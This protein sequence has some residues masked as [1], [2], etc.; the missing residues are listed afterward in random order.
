[1]N[2]KSPIEPIPDK[3]AELITFFENRGYENVKLVNHR[4][5]NDILYATKDGK[6]CF[7]KKFRHSTGADE[8]VAQKTNN[9][10]ACYKHLPKDL[11]I[12]VVEIAVNGGYV[13]LENVDFDETIEDKQYIQEIADFELCRLPNIEASFLSEIS[14]GNY[15]RLF[16]KLKKLEKEG[17]IEDADAIIR[18]FEDKKDLIMNA[19]KIFS[20]QDFNRSNLRKVNGQ[21]KFFDFEEPKQ[22]NAMF[23][24]A[25][26]SIDIRNNPELLT[27]Y[28]EK[29]QASKLYNQELFNLMT[30]RRAVIVMYARLDEIKSG[31]VSQFP[32]NNIDAF[33][34]SINKLAA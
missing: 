31:Q 12:D 29:I 7:I 25:T 8:D 22:D 18:I 20:Q 19:K 27:A 6:R 34:E 32:Q 2:E 24:M 23:D 9:E 4:S 33:N 16:E 11:L 17:I 3:E 5:R 10:L 13:A 14:W 28:K 26:M 1:M 15:E 30:V 21:L